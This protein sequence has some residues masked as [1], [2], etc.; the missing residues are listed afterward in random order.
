MFWMFGLKS[1]TPMRFFTGTAKKAV[2]RLRYS[3]TYGGG[4]ELTQPWTHRLAIFVLQHLWSS[5]GSANCEQRTEGKSFPTFRF[6]SELCFWV[7]FPTFTLR[8]NLRLRVRVLT[9]VPPFCICSLSPLGIFNFLGYVQS[10][11]F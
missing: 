9:V 5:F 7:P 3:A 2:C 1:C 11:S 8:G 10:P 6:R 4:G